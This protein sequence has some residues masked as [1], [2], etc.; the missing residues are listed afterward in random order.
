MSYG[1]FKLIK[2]KQNT[3]EMDGWNEHDDTEYDDVNF[4]VLNEHV[5]FYFNINIQFEYHKLNCSKNLILIYS[6]SQ[7]WISKKH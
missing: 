3:I 1:S 7:I 5:S 4:N 6:Y 2:Y